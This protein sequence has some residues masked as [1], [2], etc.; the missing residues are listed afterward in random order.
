MRVLLVDDS[1]LIRKM[2]VEMLN[3]LGHKVEVAADGQI[4][5]DKLKAGEEFEMILLDWNM[6]NVTGPE[7]LELAAKDHLLQC[8]VVMMTTESAEDK[9]KKALELGAAE[10]VIKPFTPEI[11]QEKLDLASGF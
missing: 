11:L 9:I 2:V 7:F 1:S 10:Y 3:S 5:Y 6:P 4:A 8:P